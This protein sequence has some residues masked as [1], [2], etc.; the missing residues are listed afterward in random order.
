M[1][2][3]IT[4]QKPSRVVLFAIIVLVVLAGI[5]FYL[6]RDTD[7][8]TTPSSPPAKPETITGKPALEPEVIDISQ[9]KKDQALQSEMDQRKLKFGITDGLDAIVQSDEVIKVGDQKVSM[10]EIADQIQL[11]SGEIIEGDIH[12][13]LSGDPDN[14][15][16]FGIYIVKPGDNIWNIH[17]RLLQDYFQHKG[18]PL[19]PRSDEP[20]PNGSSSGIGKIL[21]F[22]E[23]MV[24]IYNIK[25]KKLAVDLNII[26]PMSKIVIYNMEKVFT[27]LD[28][29]EPDGVGDIQ[30]DGETLWLSTEN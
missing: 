27:L 4:G 9:L 8:E 2:E 6:L 17:F 30:F 12:D 20:N 24:H 3:K 22:S 11:K 13:D 1:S 26:E 15:T 25:E 14:I 5:A 16:F 28:Q 18:I 23:N 7:P 10:K 19:S 21:K 29:I